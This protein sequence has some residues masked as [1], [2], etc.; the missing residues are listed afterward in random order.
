M[1]PAHVGQ[2]HGDTIHGHIVTCL[3]IFDFRKKK[4][5]FVRDM[6][7]QGKTDLHFKRSRYGHIFCVETGH[8]WSIKPERR[9][10]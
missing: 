5:I 2:C 8:K 9:N 6:H 1:S 4:I 7:I 10:R 3:D